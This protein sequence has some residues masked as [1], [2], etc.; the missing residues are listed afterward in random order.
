MKVMKLA[1]LGTAALAAASL[2]ANAN[3]LSDLKAQ[4]EALNSRIATL[5]AAP[6]VP[7][8][9]QLVSFSKAPRILAPGE[10]LEPGDLAMA[11]TFSILPTADVPASTNVQWGGRVAAA[12]VYY[13]TDEDNDLLDTNE[14]HIT[15]NVEINMTAT[16]DTAVGEVGVF[17]RW[18]ASALGDSN[19]GGSISR[20]YGW[21]KMT[22]E[23]TL[24][25]GYKDSIGGIGHGS[26]LCNCYFN[27]FTGIAGSSG[28]SSQFE[29]RYASGPIEAAVTVGDYDDTVGVGPS[30]SDYVIN[31]EV[32]FAGDSVSAEVA[33]FFGEKDDSTEVWQVGAG[34]TFTMDM[35]TL[36]ANA[37]V[38]QFEDNH[39]YWLASLFARAN[40]SDSISAEI[41]VGI[42][43]EDDFGVDVTATG[44][45]G[46]LY[47]A[48]VDKLLIGAEASWVNT[49]T[50]GYEVDKF[51]AALVTVFKF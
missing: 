4:I 44:V 33:G 48:P 14:S 37:G 35:F 32:K 18:K 10:V 30:D 27:S 2:S 24:R 23:L 22:P 12:F 38:G 46:G 43:D 34:A 5:E 28:D 7:A 40:L 29:V 6:S 51:T 36:S 16:T 21:W 9:Y 17:T 39:D 42:Q 20:Y 3:D 25:A 26:D 49:D 11:N 45:A 41:G 13:S 19:N 47:W 31:A 50:G 8:G 15:A 1:L